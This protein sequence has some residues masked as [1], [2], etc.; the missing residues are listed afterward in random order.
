MLKKCIIASAQGWLLLLLAVSA[1]A[2]GKPDTAGL[3]KRKIAN[4]Q[5]VITGQLPNGLRYYIR[6]NLHPARRAVL[7]LATKAG[8]VQETDDQQGLA[9]FTEHL[10]FK[11]TK[12][13]PGKALVDYLQ[14]AGVQLGADLNAYTSFEETVYQLPVPTDDPSVLSTGVQVLRDWA[15]DVL[16]DTTEMQQERGVIL[17]EKRQRKGLQQR[18]QDASLPVLLNQSRHT[19][20]QPIG[21]EAVIAGAA[22][23]LLR[24]F[25]RDWYRPDLQAIIAVGDFDPAT[26]ESL[27]RR[28]F[29]DLRN[30]ANPPDRV[31]YDVPLTGQQQYK[32]FTDTEITQT[33]IEVLCKYKTRATHSEQS[34]VQGMSLQLFN[35]M[36]AGRLRELQ[37]SGNPPFRSASASISSLFRGVGAAKV[38]V[39]VHPGETA[40]GFAGVWTELRRVQQHGFTANELKRAKAVFMEN[41]ANRYRER[42][43]VESKTYVN[44]YLQHFL[45][46]APYPE[47]SFYYAF[48]QRYIDAVDLP[49]VNG[50]ISRF[51]DS[52]NRDIYVLAPASL[53]VQLPQQAQIAQWVQ[54]ALS[55]EVPAYKEEITNATLMPLLPRAGK[56]VEEKQLTAIG[57]TAIILNNGVRV[58]LK[59]TRFQSDEIVV[60]SFSPGGYS[61]Y[62]E[63]DL[64]TATNAAGMV[65]QSGLSTFD[66]RSLPKL[67]ADKKVSVSPYIAELYEGINA[68][69]GRKDLE[70]AFQLMHLYF[71]QP[72]MD[73]V[74]VKTMLRNTVTGLAGRY[75]QPNNV[76][77]DT[78]NAILTQYHWRRKPPTAADIARID[79]L[80]AYEIFVERFADASDFTFVITGSFTVD[81]IKPLL[82]QYLG[83][84]PGLRRREAGINP[85]LKLPVGTLEKVVRS[86]KE[87]KA[88]VR[89]A[90][91]GHYIPS[92][93]N[94]AYLTAL[95]S[96]LNYRLTD[97]LRGKEGGVYTPQVSI[98]AWRLPE[99]TYSIHI[100]F[101]CDPVRAAQ[102]AAIAKSEMAL[103]LQEGATEVEL[104][105]STAEYRR[106]LETDQPSNVFW[107]NL[108]SLRLQW[109][110]DP[111]LQIPLALQP[112]AFDVAV[113][114]QMI[115]QYIRLD[116]LQQFILLPENEVPR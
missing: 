23:A 85:R 105:K 68:R 87:N 58:Y 2:Q 39:T 108:I 60:S 116:N 14:R 55:A 30:P 110:E 17:E 96:V 31:V 77:I 112:P 98:S 101:S 51:T 115:H 3:S 93:V 107:N 19:L 15:G 90:I 43:H 100:S 62:G 48:Y 47:D 1:H 44:K 82:A 42:D 37:Q 45:N 34:L 111:G 49:A 104:Q 80:R 102:L 73:T 63:D 66:A 4:D 27:I 36:L 28:L 46:D 10:A 91:M 81:S 64:H 65:A 32:S 86:G 84:L 79:P 35:T 12:H 18:I 54:D 88:L 29:S 69:A 13:F 89:L 97:R 9:H 94:D 106:K 52:T 114:K 83:S 71:T 95:E 20:R 103:L 24:S 6:R 99:P 70:T 67:L 8:S 53:A 38:S 50:W 7:Y 11:G 25:Y 74:L 22:P 26:M 21:R 109:G 59:P 41:Q 75:Q 92:T 76:F 16:I 113:F 5:L 33:T 40:K 61:L 57:T 78:L 72:R 56:I